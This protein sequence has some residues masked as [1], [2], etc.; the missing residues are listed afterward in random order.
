MNTI[1]CAILYG[2]LAVA[3]QPPRVQHMRFALPTPNAVRDAF[4]M[5]GMFNSYSAFNSDFFLSGLRTREGAAADRK[6]WITLPLQEHFAQRQG[7]TFTQLMAAHHW[8]VFGR[9]AQL[10]AWRVL[11]RK[12][13]ERHNRLHPDHPV[14]RVQF[15][16]M[17]W[18]QSAAGYRAR[19]RAPW[20][21]VNVWFAERPAR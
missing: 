4:L 8:D 15:G 16:S 1:A 19:K 13:R 5:N 3:L 10:D 2:N 7:V 14:A 17:D 9:P 20:T 6:Q 18:P 21:R 11:A 12:I